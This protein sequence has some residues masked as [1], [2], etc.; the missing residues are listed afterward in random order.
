MT[1]PSWWQVTIPHRDIREGKLSEAIFAADLGDVVYGKAPL[2]Y[3]DASIFF[4]KT[5]LTQGLKNLLENV[6]SRLSGGKGDAVIQLQTPFGG[7]KTH[8]L[9]A[10]YHVVRHRKEIEHL[11]AVSELPEAKDAKVTVFVGTQADAVSGK[12]PWGEIAEQ[13]GQYE[14]I[15]E[16]DKKRIAPGKEKLRQILEASGPTLILMDEILEYI[17]K[18]N[19]AEKVEK[20]TQGQTLAFLQEISEVVASSENCGL[21]ITLPASILERYDEEAERSLQQL[22][23]ISGRVEAV[24]TPVEGVE[25]Y[26]VIRKR[27]FEDLGDEKTRR[28]VAESYFKLYQSLSTDVPS[29]VKEIE[30]RERI[31]R[32]YPFHPEL[33]DVLYERWGSYPTFQRTRGVL[34]LVAEVVADLYGGKVVSPLIQSS[35]VNLENQTIRREFI[36]HIGNE[37]DS[38]ISADIAG[39]NAKAPR[40]DKEMGSE[41]ERYGTAK[42]IATSVFLYSFSA[43]A[44]RETTLPRIR[45]A[46]LREGIPATIVGDAVAKL[47][48]E[49]WYFHSERKQYAFRNQPN[50]NR[51]IVDR[52]ETISEDRIREELK[53]L[54]QKNAGR[55]L[56]VYLWPESASDIPDNKNLKLA[57]LSPSCSYDSDKG[58]R[59]AAELFEK[60]GL[61]FRVYKNTLFILLIDD[62]QHVFLNKALRRLLALGEI[63]SDKSLLETLTRQS[64]EEL[65]KKLKETEKEMPFKILMAYRY[66]GVL[67][68]GGINWKD[69]GIPTVGSSQTISERVKQYLKD[70]E[71]LLSRLTP[72]YLL[73]KTFGKDEN[74]KSLREIYE[75]H[76]KT[77][78]MPLPESEEVLLDAVIEGART[79]ILGVRENTEVYYR[80]EVTPTID[81]IVLRGEVASRIKEG[82]REEERKGGAEEEEIVKKGAIRRVTLR[83][84]IPWDKLS[85]VITGVIRPLMDRGLPP[86][87]TI[88][89]QADS[90][91]GFDRTTLDSK[92]KETLRQIDAKIEEWKEE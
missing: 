44:S 84:K 47:E 61:G 30:Y 74:E 48:E 69:L 14:I 75:L 1:L 67:E 3:R 88:E 6:L 25:I 85:A 31:E 8:A 66:L 63:Q 68:N 4:Q 23:K 17:V 9:L 82:E 70:Q 45:V 32:A 36:K 64:Q 38:V 42:G 33:I 83:A 65:N 49:L 56:E 76:L 62:N 27:L 10:L 41:Y 15:K 39:K 78:G 11:T 73:D 80:Q 35:I 26:E 50:L 51:V 92:V 77:P 72:K 43:G 19:R 79:G 54:I 28:Q 40:I 90:V 21:V 37:Y 22:Q 91:E 52:E 2:E 46:L 24:Y 57:I 53:G 58:K 12:T 71:K 16:H 60:A 20:I 89:I 18:A 55:A 87:I 86:E 5:Y 81:S 34:R 59:L 7:G 29:E 13:L